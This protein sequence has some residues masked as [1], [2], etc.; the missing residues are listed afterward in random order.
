LTCAGG[1]GIETGEP[2]A[3]KPISIGAKPIVPPTIG[4]IPC[5]FSTLLNQM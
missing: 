4:S 1:T 2:F 5:T 3:V